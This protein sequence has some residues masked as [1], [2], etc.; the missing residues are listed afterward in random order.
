[1]AKSNKNERLR[2]SGFGGQGVLTVGQ[3]IA[4]LHLEHDRTVSWIPAYGAEMR[5][6]TTNCSVIIQ[7][8]VIGSP[9]VAKDIDVLLAFN[10]PSLTRFEPLV[11]KGGKIIYNT[12]IIKD[13]PTRKDVEVIGIDATNISIALGSAKVQNMV[14]M[15]AYLKEHPYFNEEI[16]KKV[17]LIRFG[18]KAEKLIPINLAAINAGRK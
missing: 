14:M 11:R 5:G 2:I 1:M 9:I 6:G 12:S 3:I 17:L 4:L 10:L 18:E 16:L 15:G 8:D 13:P 7:D